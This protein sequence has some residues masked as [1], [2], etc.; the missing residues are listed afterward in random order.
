MKRLFNKK[1]VLATFT[2]FF[3]S[4]LSIAQESGNAE[5]IDSNQITL[6]ALVIL[7]IVI[8]VVFIVFGRLIKT[9]GNIYLKEKSK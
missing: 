5:Q 9:L 3:V 2:L 6:W 4:S 8:L 1:L 7:F